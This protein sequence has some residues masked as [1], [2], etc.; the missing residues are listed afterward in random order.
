[1]MVWELV[2]RTSCTRSR[3][4]AA[5]VVGAHVLVLGLAFKE[6]CPD[7]RNTKVVDLIQGLE[8]YGSV[9]EVVDPW[10]DPSEALRQ[11]GLKV[12]SEIPVK[13]EYGAV[14]VAVGHQ[15]FLSQ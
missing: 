15:Q 11:Y 13:G 10:I 3:S 12:A 9:V 8:S 7:L 4:E 14:V 2:C 1:M 6:N 5:E